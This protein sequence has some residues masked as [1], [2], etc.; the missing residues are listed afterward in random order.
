M[1]YSTYEVCTVLRITVLTVVVKQESYS[2]YSAAYRSAAVYTVVQQYS[3]T[4]TCQV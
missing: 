1:K 3:S 4:I 2:V